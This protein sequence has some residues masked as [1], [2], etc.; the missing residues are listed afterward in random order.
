MENAACLC[1]LGPLHP[2]P[3]PPHQ[4]PHPSRPGANSPSACILFQ[5]SSTIHAMTMQITAVSTS[6]R[7]FVL[8]LPRIDLVRK[9][10][11]DYWHLLD[12]FLFLFDSF[13]G[14]HWRKAL[15][16]W[17]LSQNPQ[18]YVLFHSS[19]IRF[20]SFFCHI[21]F[22]P[23]RPIFKMLTINWHS[24]WLKRSTSFLSCFYGG[25]K[26]LITFQCLASIKFHFLQ[27][28]SWTG[29]AVLTKVKSLPRSPWRETRRTTA[30]C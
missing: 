5:V 7:V 13:S 8:P 2:P 30:T 3:P 21:I 18:K 14:K 19:L 11:T 29:W 22:F 4:G 9:R 15:E 23:F 20:R 12:F 27:V 16:M 10:I 26:W 17:H 25:F 1:L 28:W 24:R 6:K